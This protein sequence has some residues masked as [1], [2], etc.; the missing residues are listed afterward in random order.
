MEG[1]RL[2]FFGVVGVGGVGVDGFEE[3]WVEVDARVGRGGVVFEKVYC[4]REV[5]K[6]EMLPGGLAS[7]LDIVG[8]MRGLEYYGGGL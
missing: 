2:R 5:L 4:C 3:E 1:G 7:A 8:T 6:L